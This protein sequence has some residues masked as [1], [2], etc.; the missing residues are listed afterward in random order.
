MRTVVGQIVLGLAVV[1][2][3]SQAVLNV[4]HRSNTSGSN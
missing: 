3:L 2:L 4:R 1:S